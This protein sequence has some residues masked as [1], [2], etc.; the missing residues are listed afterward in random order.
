MPHHGPT[1]P[2]SLLLTPIPMHTTLP[3]A[4]GVAIGQGWTANGDHS[5]NYATGVVGLP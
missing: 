5:A 3:G 2:V 1:T 4:S